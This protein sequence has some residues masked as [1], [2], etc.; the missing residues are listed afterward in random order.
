MYLRLLWKRNTAAT[1]RL[2]GLF[3]L[4]L[5]GL[6]AAG[7][8]RRD[9]PGHVRVRFVHAEDGNIY[10]QVKRDTPRLR[11]ASTN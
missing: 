1:P 4:G 10:L 2:L 11:V 8:I 6:L 7:F 3:K 9:G 5:T